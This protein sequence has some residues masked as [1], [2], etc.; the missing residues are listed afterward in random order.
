MSLSRRPSASSSCTTTVEILTPTEADER[1]ATEVLTPTE[2]VQQESP[3][4]HD[5]SL[6]AMVQRSPS[7]I[8]TPESYVT[9][10]THH[11]PDYDIDKN[12]NDESEASPDGSTRPRKFQR[13][14]SPSPHWSLEVS[15]RKAFNDAI[16]RIED[17]DYQNNIV[18]DY[19]CDLG[20][21]L[22]DYQYCYESAIRQIRATIA[23]RRSKFYIGITEDPIFRW[24]KLGLCRQYDY[25]MLLYAG[26]T[27]KWKIFNGDSPEVIALKSVSS[28]QM[29]RD[30]IKFFKDDHPEEYPNL[31]NKGPG[32]EGASSGCPHFTYVATSF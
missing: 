27:G 3:I 25:M 4:L 26:P 31:Q 22:P 18:T 11:T 16:Q 20:E 28:G 10:Q 29:E 8:P 23:D 15:F 32:G 9:G 6:L 1:L 13:K 24:V 21:M 12:E 5:D 19:V 14:I 17:S 2:E 30:L 7:P